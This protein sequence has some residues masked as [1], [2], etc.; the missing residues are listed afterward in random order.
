MVDKV[1]R[2][3]P[4]ESWRVKPSKEA[5]DRGPDDRDSYSGDDSPE[6][7]FSNPGTNEQWAKFHTTTE[8][9]RVIKTPRTEIKHIWFR[10]ASFRHNL[11]L[12]ECDVELK[13][14]AFH[15]SAQYIMPRMED[16][17]RFKGYAV[18]QEVPVTDLMHEQI[19]E[20]SLL[21]RRAPPATKPLKKHS[22]NESRKKEVLKLKIWSLFD[23]KTGTVRWQAVLFYMLVIV[24][25]VS[26]IMSLI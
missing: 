9:R 8:S 3:K 6:D 22:D 11:T 5:K 17:L 10:K 18:G 13:S 21:V 15:S 26:L 25:S 14:G 24:A 19:V 16:Y 12:I 2:P 7:E 4:V 23:Q 20:L 1:D